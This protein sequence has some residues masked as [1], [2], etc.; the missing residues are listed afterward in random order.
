MKL[1]IEKIQMLDRALRMR[2]APAQPAFENREDGS[3]IISMANGASQRV[4]V[5]A[6]PSLFARKDFFNFLVNEMGRQ[7]EMAWRQAAVPTSVSTLG[8]TDTKGWLRE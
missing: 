1:T 8:P 4:S 2:F 3:M 5:L 6:E 7:M